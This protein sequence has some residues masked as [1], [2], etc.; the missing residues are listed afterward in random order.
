MS[1][2]P[3]TQSSMYMKLRV[4]VAVSPNLDFVAAA[5]LGFDYLA[6]DG[7]GSFLPAAVPGAVRP[8]DVVESGHAGLHA[9]VLAEMAAHALA[10][11]LFPAVSVLGHGRIGI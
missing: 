7:G 10:E 2:M 9:E 6:A 5:G 11:E 4:R 8:V 3:L 1:W